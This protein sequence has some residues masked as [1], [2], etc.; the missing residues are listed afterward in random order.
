[1]RNKQGQRAKSKVK[2]VVYCFALCNPAHCSLLPEYVKPALF[3]KLNQP[4]WWKYAALGR[5]LPLERYQSLVKSSIICYFLGMEICQKRG[6]LLLVPAV[7]IGFSTFF[8]ETT[9]YSGHDHDCIGEGC[10][11][12]LQIEAANNFLNTLKLASI[13]FRRSLYGLIPRGLPRL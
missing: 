1:M 11:I 8:S 3:R 10:P 6:I 12:C 5:L 13:Y 4:C 2:I 7:C 9:I